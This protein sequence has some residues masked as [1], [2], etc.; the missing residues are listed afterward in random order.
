VN[1]ANVDKDWKHINH[2]LE[3]QFYEKMKGE[4]IYET[5]ESPLRFD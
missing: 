3:N 4:D 5:W 2:L 1:G